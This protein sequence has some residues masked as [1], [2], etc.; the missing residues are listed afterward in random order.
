MLNVL[1]FHLLQLQNGQLVVAAPSL[2]LAGCEHASGNPPNCWCIP[3]K[4]VQFSKAT[5]A[6]E[7]VGKGHT[8]NQ[9]GRSEKE[10]ASNR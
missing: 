8:S 3:N 10:K 7:A 9:A 1:F 6:A 4:W 5:T 2:L